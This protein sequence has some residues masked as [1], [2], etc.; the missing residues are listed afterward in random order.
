M[1]LWHLETVQHGP[2]NLRLKFCQNRFS[3]S[4]NITDI[5]F[6][7]VGWFA[8]SFSCQTQLWLNCYLVDVELG[9]WQYVH[10]I[11]TNT[12]H[13]AEVKS[14]NMNGLW[15]GATTRKM[16]PIFSCCSLLVV[17]GRQVTPHHIHPP[18]CKPW[19][20]TTNTTR[21]HPGK[22]QEISI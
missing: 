2:R 8:K 4:W 1:S 3:N 5:E 17:W 7:W 9:F 16:I 10:T 15:P 18:M 12:Q 11:Y 20:I 14:S 13:R 19:V 21:Y 22:D 6:V